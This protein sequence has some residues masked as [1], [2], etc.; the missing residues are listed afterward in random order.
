MAA[1]S[2][3]TSTYWKL[4]FCLPYASRAALVYGHVSFP[5]IHTCSA[6]ASLPQDVRQFGSSAV[7]IRKVRES[8][9]SNCP[10]HTLRRTGERSEASC[11]PALPQAAQKGPDARRDARRR[12]RRTPGTPQGVRERANAPPAAA[13]A[14]ARNVGPF[15]AACSSC[16]SPRFSRRIVTLHPHAAKR[17]MSITTPKALANRAQRQRA[18]PEDSTPRR[19]APGRLSVS[20][21]LSQ[22]SLDGSF[23]FPCPF[24]CPGPDPGSVV[25]HGRLR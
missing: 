8:R 14:A 10:L 17:T 24:P 2:R 21:L 3:V 16:D 20:S 12:L 4:T 18:N 7:Q 11:L 19:N 13:G 5:N 6:I 15:S 22:K 1:L 9:I 25:C 23:P